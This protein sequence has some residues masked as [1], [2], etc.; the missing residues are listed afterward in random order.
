MILSDKTLKKMLATKAIKCEPLT[1]QSIQGASIDCRIGNHFL[2]TEDHQMDLIDMN[3]E[4][5]YREIVADSIVIP[6][7]SFILG[8]TMEYLELPDDMTVFIEGRS[9]VGR[10]GLF[11]ENAGWVDPGF[12]GNLTLELYNA[13]T[14]PIRIYAG[15]R[16]CQLIF[17]QM[18]RKADMPYGSHPYSGKYQGQR[19]T[20][21]SRI[22][23]D[24]PDSKKYLKIAKN[25]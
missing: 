23:L 11:I 22:S 13:N 12:K 14:L 1:E 3:Q 6:P 17:A 25:L 16:L 21:G 7:K 10:M 8:T 19:N 20:V 5:K 15:R 2:V 4:I 9:S 24:V 18:D